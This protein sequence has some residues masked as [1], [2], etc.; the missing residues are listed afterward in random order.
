MY[1]SLES[2]RTLVSLSAYPSHEENGCR[3]EALERGTRHHV[4]QSCQ[5]IVAMI[6]RYCPPRSFPLDDLLAGIYEET[7]VY[8]KI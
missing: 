5:R 1:N 6:R 7:Y 2:L 8:R 3:C 4:H